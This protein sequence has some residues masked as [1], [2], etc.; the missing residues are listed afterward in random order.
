VALTGLI[1]AK[2]DGRAAGVTDHV[3]ETPMRDRSY[4]HTVGYVSPIIAGAMLSARLQNW[5]LDPTSASDHLRAGFAIVNHVATGADT[6]D[7]ARRVAV[8]S[9]I[10]RVG[11]REFALKVEED[12]RVPANATDPETLLHGHLVACDSLDSDRL[13][14]G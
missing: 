12:V 3:I 14:R 6:L 2:P 4:C 10:D 11:A 7:G 1:T 9:G 5:N 8:G 13:V